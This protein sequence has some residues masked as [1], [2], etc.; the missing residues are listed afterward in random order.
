MLEFDVVTSMAGFRELREAWDSLAGPSRGSAPFLSW[1]WFDCCLRSYGAGRTPCFVVGRRAGRV[2]GVAPLWL[3][4]ES[5]RGIR[6]RT[7]RFV[8]CPDTPVRDVVTEEGRH[9]EFVRGLL[10]HL[11][12]RARDRWDVLRAA[13]AADSP[14]L[15]EIRR[16]VER[17][18]WTSLERPSTVLPYVRISGSWQ[19]FLQGKSAKHRKTTRNIA[20]RIRRLGSVTVER[21]ETDPGGEALRA[22]MEVSARGWKQGGRFALGGDEPTRTFFEGI[23]AAASDRNWLLLWV[24]RHDDRP[25]AMEYDLQADGVVFA[26]RS[27]YDDEYAAHSAGSFLQNHILERLHEEGFR[28]YN[29]GPGVN[30][31]KLRIADRFQQSTE[32][33]LFNGNFR[34]VGAWVLEGTVVPAVR[35]IRDGLRRAPSTRAEGTRS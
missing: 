25:I 23:T 7:L 24:V 11:H 10:D 12:D 2:V 35:R 33:L 27:D 30:R 15:D 22:A 9:G 8:D 19:S 13:C 16:A 21:H 5:V 3:Q 34:A 14:T 18:G 1:D 26:L 4:R 17:R 29:T 6:L 32:T 28:V 31:Y 20:N